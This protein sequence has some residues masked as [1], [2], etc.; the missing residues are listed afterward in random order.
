MLGILPVD[1][2]TTNVAAAL[3]ARKRGLKLPDAIHIATALNFNC[4]RFLTA[5]K[6]IK[7]PI[8][9]PPDPL[10]NARGYGY[11]SDRELQII[12]PDAATLSSLL[13]EFTD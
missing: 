5:D 4:K 13:A 9:R 6:G 10:R 2:M 12:R 7:G 11:H 1:Q 3:R 8:S